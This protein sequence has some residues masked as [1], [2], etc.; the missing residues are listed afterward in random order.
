VAHW[1]LQH[2]PAKAGVCGLL[3][4]GHTRGA[5]S[6]R[7]YRER[8]AAGDDVAVWVS[9][10]RGGVVALGSVV[11][12][13]HA[14][15]GGGTVEVDLPRLFVDDPIGRDELRADE[16]F[17]DALVL[18]MPGGANPFPLTPPQ[19]QAILDRAP[20]A[21][22]P[23]A[24]ESIGAPQAGQHQL[25]ARTVLTAAAP[26]AAGATAIREAVRSVAR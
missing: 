13:P 12:G 14:E 8:I 1:L 21:S 6:I 3:R 17:A 23:D 4:P 19:W 22:R 11:D 20:A 25:V 5:W 2:N 10:R 16:R 18:R 26:A 9:G 15:P 7:R 24:P